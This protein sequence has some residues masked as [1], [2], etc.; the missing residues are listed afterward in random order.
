MENLEEGYEVE[1]SP[2][3]SVKEPSFTIN[4]NNVSIIEYIKFISKISKLNFIYKEE[5]LNFNVTIIS[6]EPTSLANVKSALVQVLKVNGFS[7]I[8]QGNNAIITASDQSRQIATVVSKETPLKEGEQVPPIMTRVFKVNNANPSVLGRLLMPLLSQGAILEVSSETRHVIITD[9]SQNIEQIQKLMLTLDLPKAPFNID[10]Y[11]T[12]NSGPEDLIPFA[13]RIIAPLSEGNPVLFVGQAETNTIFIVS[14]PFLI[15]KALM[16]LE[17]LDTPPALIKRFQG[18]ITG[19]NVLLYH[20]QNKSADVLQAGIKAVI[21]QLQLAGP[22]SQDLVHTLQSMHYIRQSHS[23]FFNGNPESLAEIK[24][25][26]ISLDIPFSQQE[27]EFDGGRF[28]IYSIQNGTEEQIQ[29]SLNKFVNNLKSSSHPDEGLIR[30][31]STMKWIKEN[32]SLMFTG[33]QVSLDKLSQILRTFDIPVNQGKTASRLPLSNDFYVYHPKFQEGKELLGQVKE[34]YTTLKNSGLSDPPF[35]NTLNSAKW[36]ASTNS[37][38]FTG[39]SA[40]LDRVHAL[41]GLMDYQEAAVP[42]KKMTVYMYQ[43]QFG[44]PHHVEKGLKQFAESLSHDEDLVHAIDNMKYVSQSNT[45]IFRAFPQTINRIKEVLLTLD[46][47]KFTESKSTYVVYK[48]KNAQGDFVLDEL[49]QTAKTLSKGN[50]EEKDLVE[51]IQNIQWNQKTNSLVLTGPAD[52]LKKLE[53]MIT[54]YDISHEEAQK[55]SQFFVY[56]NQTMSAFEFQKTIFKAA[57]EMES[58]GLQNPSLIAALR[59]AK[60]ISNGEAL[61]FTGTPEAITKL[62]TIVPNLEKQVQKPNQVYLFTPKIRSP[63]EIIQGADQTADEMEAAQLADVSL[64]LAFRSGKIVGYGKSV[65]FTG[66]PSAIAKVEEMIPTFDT[67]KKESLNSEF[68]VYKPQNISAKELQNHAE[69]VAKQMENAGLSDPD[70]INCLNST[71]LVSNDTGLLFTGTSS[72]IEKLKSL[73]PSLDQVKEG[74]IQQP[75]KT[76]F[77]IY[78]IK[79]VSASTLMNYLRSMAIDLQRAGSSDTGVINALNNIRY[80]KKTNTIIFTGTPLV[81]QRVK[82]IIAQFDIPGM[83]QVEE[84]IRSAPGFLIYSPKYVPGQQLI[85]I[86]KDFEQNLINSG[87]EEADL[88]DAINNLRWM[89]SNASILISGDDES[90]KRVL[91]LLERFDVPGQQPSSEEEGSIE[92]FDELSFLIYKLQYHSGIEIQSSLQ[93]IG[94]DLSRAKGDKVNQDLVESIRGL[95]WIEVTNSLITT[96]K[97]STLAKLRELIKSIDIPLKQ[98]FVE[99]LVIETNLSNSLNFGLRW[100]SQGNYRNKFAYGTGAFPQSTDT[101]KDELTSFNQNLGQVNATT[102]PNVS[103]SD[104]TSGFSLGVIG[105]IILHK[106]KSYFALGSLIDAIQGDSE[107]TIALSQ[108]VITQDNKNSTI[109]VGQNVPYTGSIITSSSSAITASSNLEYRDV[110]VNLSITPQV[111]GDNLITLNI[112]EEISE[113][114]NNEGATASNRLNGITTSKTTTQTQ[115][116][117]PDRSFLV[118]SGQINNSKSTL[119]TSIPCLGGLPVVGAAFQQNDSLVNHTC[120]LIF[121]RPHIVKSFEEY[122]RITERQEDLH[123][124]QTNDTE[125]YDEGLELVKTPDDY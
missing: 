66:T 104:P 78:K 46:S 19:K 53:L 115:V 118:L 77:F 68:F 11:S 120:I 5:E 72:S 124:S 85:V 114:V 15:E 55:A 7:L 119:R 106:G 61:I 92:S 113:V 21:K 75:V 88:F 16:I 109:F 18:P 90:N 51:A 3:P 94:K 4:F 44:D 65:L 12:K 101:F 2:I 39:D 84:P 108:K 123:R 52:V 35:L 57:N 33:D 74:D 112:N 107:S 116:T 42:Q 14:T 24:S 91:Q 60:I 41:M 48:L 102:N 125:A 22:A 59:S 38:I 69:T 30:A 97:P 36:V 1:L 64:I 122:K 34:V 70:L 99:V 79:Y 82:K 37:L 56:Q 105:D 25:I 86:L 81:L 110:G 83:A 47:S 9:I 111:S 76:S 40:S 20:I 100:G 29:A 54:E 98:V 96:G 121:V 80:I 67:G 45:L 6:E 50:V 49:D 73:L 23:L 26:L 89:D 32:N 43:I 58:S 63:K 27:L 103:I 95:Q 10:S 8:E 17:D 62:H 71:K 87:I 13:E 117:L 93:V 31:I 28:Y